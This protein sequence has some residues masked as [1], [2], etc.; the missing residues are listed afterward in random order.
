MMKDNCSRLITLAAAFIELIQSKYAYFQ[1]F[2]K[3][4]FSFTHRAR[5]CEQVAQLPYKL[6]NSLTYGDD[7]KHGQNVYVTVETLKRDSSTG[8]LTQAQHPKCS[9]YKIKGLRSGYTFTPYRY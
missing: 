3:C 4:L 8:G 6:P 1:W 5:T 7:N 2:N 9:L